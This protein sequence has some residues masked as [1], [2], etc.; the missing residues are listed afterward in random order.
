MVQVVGE[1]AEADRAPSS[2]RE[3]GGGGQST[4]L[5]QE[6]DIKPGGKRK[7]MNFSVCVQ[8]TF[9]FS[10]DMGCNFCEYVFTLCLVRLSSS[11]AESSESSRESSQAGREKR[12]K[13]EKK[14]RS[15]QSS[16]DRERCSSQG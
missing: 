16:S 6:L 7:K 14:G 8:R 3:R 9:P 2:K 4:H 5:S 11:R 10:S 15:R 13:R 12:K 1:E